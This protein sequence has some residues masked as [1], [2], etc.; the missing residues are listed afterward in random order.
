M[1]RIAI[2][3]LPLVAASGVYLNLSFR[4]STGANDVLLLLQSASL[5]T[6]VFGFVQGLTVSAL[7]GLGFALPRVAY[8]PRYP[9]VA[10]QWLKFG[11]FLGL[12]VALLWVSPFVMVAMLGAFTISRFIELRDSNRPAAQGVAIED[13]LEADCPRDVVLAQAWRDG[14]EAFYV[15]NRT[16]RTEELRR[17]GVSWNERLA[18]VSAV[19]TPDVTDAAFALAAAVL[20]IYAFNW[21]ITPFPLGAEVRVDFR[22]ADSVVGYLFEREPDHVVV[23]PKSSPQVSMYLAREISDF[24]VC[25]DERSWFFRPGAAVF[26]SA[27]SSTS[28]SCSDDDIEKRNAR[29]LAERGGPS[30]QRARL[31][32]PSLS[33]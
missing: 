21:L 30:L 8:D 4:Y 31:E 10:R 11:F 33:N 28:V 7:M 13:L 16:A 32:L 25:R 9:H 29:R 23:A 15:M 22:E 2:A 14:K 12:G 17:I 3:A 26:R 27:S 1:V 5:S 20:G 18:E 19:E 6:L 24:N